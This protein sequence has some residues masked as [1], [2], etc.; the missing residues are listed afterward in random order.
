MA[1]VNS[2]ISGTV[3]TAAGGPTSATET[4]RLTSPTDTAIRRTRQTRDQRRSTRR[5]FVT[6]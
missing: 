2:D 5:I 3:T 4:C 1:A 6:W